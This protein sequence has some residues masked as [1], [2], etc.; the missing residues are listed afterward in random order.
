MLNFNILTEEQ[1]TQIIEG[2]YRILE[3]IGVEV[4]NEKALGLLKQLG[5]NVEDTRVTISRKVVEKALATA[6]SYIKIYDRDGNEKMNLGGNNSYYGSGPTCP[7]FIDARTGERR[8]ATKQDAV[9]TA[10]VADYL[11]GLDFVMSLTMIGDQTRGL[12]DIHGV[13]AMLR[14]TVKP[15]ATWAFDDKNTQAIIDMCAAVKGGLKELQEKPNVIVYCEPTTPLTHCKEALD[16]VMI[17][18]ENRIPVIYSP[19]MLLG[20]TAPVTVAGGMTVGL[21]ESLTG[22]VVHQAV[23]PGAPFISSCAGCVMDMKQMKTPYGAPQSILLYGASNEIYRHLGIPSFGLAGATDAKRIDAQAGFESALQ[24]FI[25]DSCGGN[26]IHDIGFMDYGLTGSCQQMVMCNEIIGFVRRLRYGVNVDENFL[27][28]DA[29]KEVGPGGNYLGAVHTFQHF[30]K[31]IWSP[32]ISERRSYE[33]WAA[34]GEKSLEEVI[35]EKVIEILDTHKVAPLDSNIIDKLN[36][37]VA[38][39]EDEIN[40]TTK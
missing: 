17:L 25:N 12:A 34:A 5:C 38:R 4:H 27:G 33:D 37:I 21:A 18:A 29:V 39:C 24:I 35:N 8:I 1:M 15:I 23:S 3:T 2:A 6:P 20:G 40:K 30:R 28:Y 26:L 16:K 36:E 11:K 31:E 22:L 13:D 14:N 32:E 10:I 19:G 7:N 9:D